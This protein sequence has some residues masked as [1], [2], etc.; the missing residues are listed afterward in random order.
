M[1]TI[2]EPINIFSGA[3][4][5]LGAALTNPTELARS[6]GKLTKAYPVVFNGKRYPDAET[7]YQICKQYTQ[8]RVALMKEV[9]VAKFLQHPDLTD[10]VRTNGGATWLRTCSHLTNAKSDNA[11]YW[12]GVGPSSPFIRV[13]ADAYEAYECGN[14]VELGQASLF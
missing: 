8:D 1:T 7:A 5:W 14:I 3:S 4:T 13:L 6:K 2:A 11:Q 12:E 9:I 10:A